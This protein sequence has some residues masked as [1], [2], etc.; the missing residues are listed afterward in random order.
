MYIVEAIMC[1]IVSVST[2][3]LCLVCCLCMHVC[4]VVYKC[5]HVH[6]FNLV[7]LVYINVCMHV[8]VFNFVMTNFLF[9]FFFL[10]IQLKAC[11]L[12]ASVVLHFLLPLSKPLYHLLYAIINPYTTRY[13]IMYVSL[14]SHYVFVSFLFTTR[15]VSSLVH[16]LSVSLT[17]CCSFCQLAIINLI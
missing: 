16:Y 2:V 15:F 17:A 7:C 6:M 5:K 13:L 3:F 9:L 4:L 8:H 1:I 14:K 10:R 12:V 11:I